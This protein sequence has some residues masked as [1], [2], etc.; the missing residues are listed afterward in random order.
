MLPLPRSPPSLT[1]LP[2]CLQDYKPS[3]WL[4]AL[5]GTRLYFNMSDT[6]HI[7]SKMHGLFKELGESGRQAHMHAAACLPHASPHLTIPPTRLTSP[8]LTIPPTR[9]LLALPPLSPDHPPPVVL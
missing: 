8:H 9:L 1:C 2:A 3:G 7:P 6:R 4:G 5:M